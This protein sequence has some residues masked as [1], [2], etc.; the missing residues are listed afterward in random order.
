[1]ICMKQTFDKLQADASTRVPNVH[2][3]AVLYDVLL[4]FQ[5]ECPLCA[6]VSFGTRIKQMVPA[7]C[8]CTNEMLF[9]V[10]MDCPGC[11]DCA[12][13]DGNCPCAALVFP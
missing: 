1:M 12:C 8:L 10:R 4:A 9:K 6:S 3:I 5:P 13:V 7:N 11:V 2:Y